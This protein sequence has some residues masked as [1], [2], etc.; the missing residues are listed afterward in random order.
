MTSSLS[1]ARFWSVIPC[2][3]SPV[4]SQLPVHLPDEGHHQLLHLFTSFRLVAVCVTVTLVGYP[5]G[6]EQPWQ[7][8]ACLRSGTKHRPAFS[9]WAISIQRVGQ[10]DNH[11]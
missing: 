10:P 8:L 1:I 11:I 4:D 5:Q 9:L 3:G 2:R 7:T 6:E